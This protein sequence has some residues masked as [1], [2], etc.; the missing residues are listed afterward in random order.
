MFSAWISGIQEGF[1]NKLRRQAE[2][3]SG[4]GRGRSHVA[5]ETCPS[6]SAKV[7]QSRWA[8]LPSELLLDI[9]RRVEVSE[10]SWPAWRDVVCCAAVCRSWR[11]ATKDVVRTPE[12]CGLLTFPMSLKQVT[13]SFLF[14]HFILYKWSL[15]FMLFPFLSWDQEILQFNAI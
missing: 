13:S 14:F 8:D 12:Q 7:Q 10:T 4:T 5:P 11:Y 2:R 1:D 9:I 15:K 6:P 3:N